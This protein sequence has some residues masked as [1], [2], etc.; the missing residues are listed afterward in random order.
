MVPSQSVL[1]DSQFRNAM[2]PLL[3]Y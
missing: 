3:L 1:N 2:I